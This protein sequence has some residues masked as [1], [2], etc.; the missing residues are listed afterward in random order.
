MT[1]PYGEDG[2]D[3]SFTLFL[4]LSNRL[5][6]CTVSIISLLVLLLESHFA[7]APILA[8]MPIG[9]IKSSVSYAIHL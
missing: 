3:F 7:G 4:V 2:E 8:C 1:K 9:C 5:T 6:T